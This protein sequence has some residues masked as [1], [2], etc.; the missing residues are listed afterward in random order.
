MKTIKIQK[1]PYIIKNKGYSSIEISFIY[2]LQYN[3]SNI[4]NWQLIRQI[5]LNSSG[6]YKTETEF[7][8]QK[9]KLTIMNLSMPFVYE[10][11]TQF[12]IFD[13][14]VPDPKQISSF[15]LEKSIKF[16]IETI[17][18]PNIENNK[19]NLE[20]YKREKNCLKKYYENQNNNHN[21]IAENEFLDI[22]DN[23]GYLKENMY[24]NM[25]LIKQTDAKE[26][27]KLYKNTIINQKPIILIYGD[28]D[29]NIS[30]IIKKYIKNNNYNQTIKI[31]KEKYYKPFKNPK[32]IIKKSKDNQSHLFLGYKVNNMKKEYE[33][34]IVIL[35]NILGKGSNNLM[36]NVLRYE[37]NLLYYCNV[38]SFSNYGIMYVNLSIENNKKEL[39]LKATKEIFEKLKTKE[40]LKE[41]I[42]KMIKDLDRNYKEEV[43]TRTYKLNIFI[44]K[45]LKRPTEKQFNNKLKK[46][47][48]DKFI[49]FLDNLENDT[50]YFKEGEYGD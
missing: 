25:H 43:D 20:R 45:L 12:I 47:D 27:Y 31:K 26:I 19:F 1:E 28:V 2:P 3:K 8:K 50:V 6:K 24:H 34:Y 22:F 32:N 33:D 4:F 30:N 10:G 41:Y 21:V 23:E 9:R 13:L 38:V 17:Y 14:I 36:H 5:V 46:L 35:R 18:N 29:E 48:L 11:D 49:D 44:D 39:A 40:F 42:D 16:F 15:D 37:Y 7:I